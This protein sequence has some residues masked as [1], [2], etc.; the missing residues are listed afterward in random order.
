MEGI[1]A[2]GRAALGWGGGV[3]I[4]RRERDAST[5]M[6]CLACPPPIGAFTSGTADR[7]LASRPSCFGT[8]ED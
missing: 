5:R 1:W 7:N 8:L 3:A 6:S 2:S 4:E